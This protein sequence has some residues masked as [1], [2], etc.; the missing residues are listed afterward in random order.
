MEGRHDDAMISM[1]DAVVVAALRFATSEER[2]DETMS[3]EV[4]VA[5][6]YATSEGRR[7]GTT[8]GA[9]VVDG[10]LP[11]LPIKVFLVKGYCWPCRP[12]Q[13]GH[14]GRRNR[15]IRSRWVNSA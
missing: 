4:V 5:G 2:R 3:A 1:R 7:D 9:V 6:R 11:E 12:W 8:T 10:R 13:V 14:E 15:L